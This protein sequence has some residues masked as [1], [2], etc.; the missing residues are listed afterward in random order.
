VLLIDL[1]PPRAFGLADAGHE[2]RGF[3]RAPD[4]R[5][6]E[7]LVDKY[8]EI[9]DVVGMTPRVVVRDNLG[10]KWLGRTIWTPRD[11]DT[12]VIQL[13]KAVLEHEDTLERVLAHEMIHHKEMLELTEADKAR[14]RIGI[15]PAEHGEKFKKLARKV[16][17]VMGDDFVTEKS[18][19]SYVQKSSGKTFFLLVMPVHGGPNYGF[20]W[21]VKL[22]PNARSY[23]EKLSE[24]GAR[25]LQTTDQ[26]WA[27]G[28]KLGE[29]RGV[30]VPV[31][32]E[33]QEELRQM[34]ERVGRNR[35]AFERDRDARWQ[36]Q[37]RLRRE[38][39]N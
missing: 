33:E 10:S 39:E 18:D 23:F 8:M 12:T 6:V 7:D 30:S 26:R 34:Y 9:L 27:R 3:G 32:K 21:A 37:F 4:L 19:Q 29:R 1:E 38:G 20:A 22:T 5:R 14:L 2:F 31:S 17:D 28:A 24:S 13:Q 11:P 25:L 15:R 36:E 35:E 16:N